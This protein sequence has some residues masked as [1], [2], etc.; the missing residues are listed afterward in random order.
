[1][2]DERIFCNACGQ[3]TKHIHVWGPHYRIV[4]TA[5]L[6]D[7]GVGLWYF[8]EVSDV[9]VCAGCDDSTLRVAYFQHDRVPEGPD[10]PLTEEFFDDI[11]Y[12]PERRTSRREPKQYL[13]LPGQLRKTYSEVVSTFNSGN[14]TLCSAGVRMLLEGICNDRG[15]KGEYVEEPGGRVVLNPG[16]P[17]KL[18]LLVENLPPNLRDG[19]RA[20]KEIA[21]RA[22]HGLKPAPKEM[23]AGALDVLEGLLD[24]FYELDYKA[25][26]LVERSKRR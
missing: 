4:D 1:M 9:F 8:L 2:N 19:V 7:D 21:E 24:A 10:S 15:I 14:Y 17:K 20:L 25:R 16:L 22:I 11:E 18:N 26:L 12:F 5:D 13:S 3:P 23:L 6:T